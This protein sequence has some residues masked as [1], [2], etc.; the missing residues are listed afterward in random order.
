MDIFH[1]SPHKTPMIKPVQNNFLPPHLRLL[2]FRQFDEFLDT[3]KIN[4][5]NINH[6]KMEHSLLRD[7]HRST[8]NT[9]SILCAVLI[10]CSFLVVLVKM[11]F[12][13]KQ[14]MVI[15]SSS[16]G[17][18]PIALFKKMVSGP[19][20]QTGIQF[21]FGANKRKLVP[22]I[23]VKVLPLHWKVPYVLNSGLIALVRRDLAIM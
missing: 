10:K 11:S 7:G 9:R 12:F 2:T 13:N 19:Q 16:F 18:L 6:L 23:S 5:N 14:K 1:L 15:A 17:S 4:P 21:V 20:R 8:T 22:N 3:L